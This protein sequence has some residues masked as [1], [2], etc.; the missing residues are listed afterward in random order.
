MGR[1][2]YSLFLVQRP[3]FKSTGEPGLKLRVFMNTIVQAPER[4]GNIV[5]RDC[6]EFE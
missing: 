2:V 3:A 1:Q 5:N 4:G 6:K